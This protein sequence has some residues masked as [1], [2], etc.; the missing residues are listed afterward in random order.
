MKLQVV[1]KPK[2]FGKPGYYEVTVWD[3]PGRRPTH[4]YIIT[5][6]KNL[7]D[8][9]TQF[10]GVWVADDGYEIKVDFL[11]KKVFI[12]DPQSHLPPE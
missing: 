7:I 4:K 5:E 12:D 1:L 9:M 10:F 2:K 3:K 6:L 11:N 8:A